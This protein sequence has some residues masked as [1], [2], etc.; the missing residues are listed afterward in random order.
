LLFKIL[1]KKQSTGQATVQ[2]SQTGTPFLD[3]QL[4][5]SWRANMENAD[6]KKGLVRAYSETVPNFLGEPMNEA[7]AVCTGVRNHLL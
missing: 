7:K 4:L 5:A 3:F 6:Q 2:L 1:Y